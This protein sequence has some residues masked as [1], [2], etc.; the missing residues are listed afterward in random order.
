MQSDVINEL[1]SVTFTSSGNRQVPFKSP[2]YRGTTS[3]FQMTM[4]AKPIF[5][6]DIERIVDSG[7]KAAA[8]HQQEITGTRDFAAA[9]V[10][11]I[12]S[13]APEYS[14]QAKHI[15][16][17][18]NGVMDQ[19]QQMHDAEE[20]M[21]DDLNDLS[22]RY[23]AMNRQF[24][25]IKTVKGNIES[26]KRK[27]LET[28]VAIKDDE[29]RGGLKQVKLKTDLDNFEKGIRV[30]MTHL[31][32]LLESFAQHRERYT[33]FR[34]RRIRNGCHTLGTVVKQCLEVQT[35]LLDQLERECKQAQAT[36]DNRLE[37]AK[38]AEPLLAAAEEVPNT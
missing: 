1:Y 29:A 2:L 8:A 17:L 20:R 30:Q 24:S 15:A 18:I 28:R 33:E 23:D 27:I 25:E 7:R 19:D 5:L 4:E 36:L 37:D 9:L 26:T 34:V 35:T 13:Q 21:I 6:P 11:L 32:G 10:R 31:E 16:A 14:E 22:A 3:L 38:E 12:A